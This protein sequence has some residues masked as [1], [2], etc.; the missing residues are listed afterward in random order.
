MKRIALTQRLIEN[1]SYYEV[2]ECLDINWFRF[3]EKLDFIPIPISSETSIENIFSV[4]ALDGIILTGGNDLYSL[5]NNDLS[6][7]RD[8]FEFNLL[9]ESI[10]CDIPILGIC[11]GM[12]II[13]S[14]FGSD[15]KKIT[16]HVSNK[17]KII[18]NKDSKYFN[19]FNQMESVNSFHNYAI[20]KIDKDFIVSCNSEDNQIEAIE[21]KFKR[22]LGIMWHPEREKY[23]NINDINLIKSFFY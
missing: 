23:F 22:I 17:H 14:F 2:R 12:Q 19:L 1:D 15:L 3:F 13:S 11:R 7:K 8:D 20:E 4:M 21:H 18:S 16:N 5:N 9:K 10:K 6:K